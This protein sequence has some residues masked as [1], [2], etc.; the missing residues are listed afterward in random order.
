MRATGGFA[1]CALCPLGTTL[2]LRFFPQNG[3][4]PLSTGSQ[5]PPSA[6]Q[7]LD[8]V[9]R[10]HARPAP[11]FL[12]RSSS[13][14]APGGRPTRGPAAYRSAE[15]PVGRLSPLLPLSQADKEDRPL[16]LLWRG[17][18]G[19]LGAAQSPLGTNCLFAEIASHSC[20]HGHPRM[21]E[22]AGGRGR[23]G[24][25][26]EGRRT[27]DSCW[28]SVPLGCTLRRSA[29]VSKGSMLFQPDC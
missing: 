4:H 8:E 28:L 7:P 13:D 21:D 14:A 10:L 22:G 3:Q 12:F 26:W 23:C 18:W 24:D 25:G 15:T 5:P 11:R 9:L 17:E 20:S 29:L 2:G 6:P 27:Y 19:L 1:D 16:C